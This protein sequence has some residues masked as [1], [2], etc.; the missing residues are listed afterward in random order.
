MKKKQL[1]LRKK[2]KDGL[3]VDRTDLGGD[4][5]TYLRLSRL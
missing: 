5:T 1:D 2:K 3:R 4:I